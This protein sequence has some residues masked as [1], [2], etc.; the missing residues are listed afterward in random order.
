MNS[1]IYYA[2]VQTCLTFIFSLVLLTTTL[3]YQKTVHNENNV[4]SSIWLSL[5]FLFGITVTILSW[6]LTVTV[7]A[8]SLNEPNIGV[9]IIWFIIVFVSCAQL[10]TFLTGYCADLFFSIYIRKDNNNDAD[11][12]SLFNTKN[13]IRYSI[14]L[15]FTIYI[16]LTILGFAIAFIVR[17]H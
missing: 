12:C 10:S 9:D 1:Y 17:P 2:N 3:W 13:E 7:N 15:N 6:L 4:L 5:S 11:H 14:I 16:F 8:I